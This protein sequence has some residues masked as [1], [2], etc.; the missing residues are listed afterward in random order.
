MLLDVALE[1]NLCTLW[2]E[3]FAALLTATA[4][5]VAASFS[6]HTC[7]EPVLLFTGAFGRLEG[8]FHGEIR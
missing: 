4:E 7:A 5:A 3:A 2:K 8:A 1:V 6:A